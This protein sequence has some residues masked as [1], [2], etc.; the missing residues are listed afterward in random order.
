MNPFI[1]S[2][3]TVDAFISELNKWLTASAPTLCIAYTDALFDFKKIA[4]HLKSLNI[5]LLGTTTCGEICNDKVLKG[6]FTALFLTVDKQAYKIF[7]ASFGKDT[8]TSSAKLSDFAITNYTNP[9]ILVYASGIGTSGDAVVD[10]IK[11]KLPNKTPIYGG[12]AGDSLRLSKYTVF[13]NAVFEEDGL[14]AVVFDNDKVEINGKSFGGYTVIGKTHMA[15]KANKNIIYEI[16]GFPAYDL[17]D[18]YFGDEEYLI[19]KKAESES[20]DLEFLELAGTFPLKLIDDNNEEYFRSP[21]YSNK[22]D[23]SIILAGDIPEGGKFKFC[24]APDL[25]VSKQTVNYFNNLSKT[26]SNVDCVILNNCAGRS[27]SFGPLF[28]EEISQLRNIWNVP[29]IGFL[30]I[31]E[32]GNCAKTNECNFHNVSISLTTLKQ[33]K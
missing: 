7:T 19:L 27:W 22:K 14:A 15:T 5:D 29:T 9:G 4:T 23:K 11:S 13:T 18:Q 12:L 31:G 1:I 17:F 20:E 3:N 2:S 8:F 10:G 28:E 24:A 32:I 6:T 25:E 21:L 16:D 30:A 26:L 33:I